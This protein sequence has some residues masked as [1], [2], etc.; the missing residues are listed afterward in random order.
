MFDFLP[1][2][3]ELDAM[4]NRAGGLIEAGG[5]VVAILLVMSVLALAITFLKLWHFGAARIGERRA[6]R[7]AVAAYRAGRMDEA[8]AHAR[9]SRSPAA[10]L[11]AHAIAAQ[12]RPEARTETV[13]EEVMSL[14]ADTLESLRSYLRPLEVIAALAP[15]LGLFGTVLGMIEAFQELEAAGSRVNPAALSGGIWEALLTTAVGLA[16]AIPAVA[17]PQRLANRPRR[18]LG[19]G[20]TPLID[21]VFI[22]LVFFMLASSFLDWRT[23]SLAPPTGASAEATMEG[24]YLV[25]IRKDD[26]RLAG[27]VVP[28]EAMAAELARAVAGDDSARVLLKPDAGVPLQRAITV[29][30]TLTAAGIENIR[31]VRAPET[32]EARP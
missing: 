18:R 2:A 9:G 13:R 25:E 28:L 19:I 27:Q 1:S 29:L 14:G 26:V 15:L 6:A 11:A 22:L 3:P 12:Q 32:G 5:P 8:L 10:R 31:F 21:V 23:I 16:V 4:L 30:E 7:E 20:L 17:M 24:A